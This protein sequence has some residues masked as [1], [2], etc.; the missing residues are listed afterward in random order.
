[1]TFFIFQYGL[2]SSGVQ[3]AREKKRDFQRA[4]VGAGY[5]NLEHCSKE[6]DA[7][8]GPIGRNRTPSDCAGRPGS[9][10]LPAAGG[11]RPTI[12]Y[13]PRSRL[14]KLCLTLVLRSIARPGALEPQGE[15]ACRRRQGVVPVCRALWAPLGQHQ[16]MRR[17]VLTLVPSRRIDGVSVARFC[18]FARKK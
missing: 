4:F 18:L 14:V 9:R 11:H 8:V 1:M 2:A 13:N 17:A 16:A 12:R 15:P 3:F 6:N 10:T 7:L 5:S